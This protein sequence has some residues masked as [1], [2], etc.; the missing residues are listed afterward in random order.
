MMAKTRFVGRDAV[1]VKR[2][3]RSKE[4]LAPTG[5]VGDDGDVGSSRV[6]ASS[7]DNGDS[8]SSVARARLLVA[9]VMQDQ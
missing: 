8:G 1:G 6:V 9:P 4:A 5:A 2:R 7:V 3:G